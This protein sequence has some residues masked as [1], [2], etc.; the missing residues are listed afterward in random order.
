MAPEQIDGKPVDERCDIFA[1]GVILYEM[2]AGRPAFSGDVPSS[3]MAAILTSQPVPLRSLH[4]EVSAALTKVV[5]K[6]LAKRP[7]DR[8]ASADAVAAALRKLRKTRPRGEARPATPAEPADTRRL[9]RPTTSPA[10]PMTTERP[11]A[12]APLEQ[13][14]TAPTVRLK[15]D[16][17]YGFGTRGLWLGTLAIVLLGAIGALFVARF[18]GTAKNAPPASTVNASPR[19]SI[20]VLGFRNLAG[21][22]DAAWLSTAFAEM[23]TTELTAGE[24]IRAIA[25]ENVARMKIE[26]KLMETDS[27]AQD[28]LARIKKNLGTDLIVVGSYVAV[29]PAQDRKVRLDLRVQATQ[30]GE[31]VASVSDT[32]D[33]GDLLG[34]V[35]RIGSRVRTELGMT[36]LSAA[37]SAG[38]RASLPSSTDAIRL[39]AQGLEKYR[40]FDAIGARDLLV[41]AVT[42]DP[43]NAVA[44]SALAA[45]WSALGYDAK[46]REEAERAADLSTSLPR[47]QRLAVEARYRALAGDSQKGDSELRRAV[48]A[49]PGQSRLWPGP[50]PV[51]DVRRTCEGGAGDA[52]QAAEASASFGRRSASRSRRRDGELVAGQLHAGPRGGDDGGA[53]RARSAAR[54]CSWPRPAGWT[55]W[56]SGV[57]GNSPRPSP[58]ARKASGWPATPATRIWKR[59][60]S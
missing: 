56:P 3:V 9:R 15:E 45:A 49:L 18:S 40:L 59:S 52:R 55:A 60:P 51:P 5:A 35:S 24:Q 4:P 29:G 25:G 57:W 26:L 7:A 10:V 47:E 19:R 21:R 23:L 33:E 17:T 6:C 43:S 46:A 42:A 50:D 36:V 32:G 54:R 39:Y 20:A 1:L 13:P 8:W 41:R 11:A 44:R 53:K 48:A 14:G 37:E 58:R 38:V 2:L 12:P 27:Y 16:T 31:T 34:L 22:P 30:A 28:T